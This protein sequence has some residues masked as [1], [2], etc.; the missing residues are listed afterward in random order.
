M[1][2]VGLERKVKVAEVALRCLVCG[3]A[4]LAAALVGTGSQT[5]TFFSLE[6]KARFTDMK[7]LVFLVAAHAAAAGNSLLQLARCAAA[8]AMAARGSGNGGGSS[9]RE[10]AVAWSVFSCDQ[11]VAYVLM[12]VT[13]AALQSSVLGKRGQPQLQWMPIC[14]LYGAFCRRVGEGL[15]SAVAAGLASVLLAAVS[16]FNLFRLYGGRGKR[17][18]GAGNGATTW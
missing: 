9:G 5:R 6:K 15:A 1:A 3:L 7:A 14:G 18:S 16:A 8:A 10:A 4:A 17:S 2:V 11:A 13:A 12:A